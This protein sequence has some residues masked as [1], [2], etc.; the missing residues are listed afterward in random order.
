MATDD[1]EAEFEGT[2]TTELGASIKELVS[3]E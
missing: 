3:K 2:E 1:N